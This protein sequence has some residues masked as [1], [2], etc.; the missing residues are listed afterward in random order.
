MGYSENW[1]AYVAYKAQSGKGVQASGAG[2]LILPQAGGQGGRL[3][4][5]AIEDPIIRR[6]AMQIRG[7]HGSQKTA[8]TYS[9]TIAIGASDPI[10]AAIM[11]TGYSAADLAITQATMT[12][13]T[14]GANTI[15]AAAGS[16][17]TQGLRVGDVIRAAGLPDAANNGKNF[18]ITGLTALTIT[19]A[20]TLVVN[21]VADNAFTITRPGRVLTNPG[22]GGLVKTYFT[23]E[24]HEYDIDGSEIFTDCVWSRLRIAMSPDGV[25]TTELG[26]TGTGQFETKEGV[27]APFFTAPADP[28]ALSLAAVESVLRVGTTDI[29]DLTSFDLTIDLQ[30][31]APSVTG[32]SKYAPDVFLG[33]Q[34]LTLNLTAMRKDLLDVADFI[35]ENQLSLH[36]LASEHENAPADFMSL[37]IPNF[38]YGGID[39]S[40]LSKQGGARTVTRSVPSS[41]IGIDSRGGAFDATQIK[42]QVSNAT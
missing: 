6:D 39:K 5:A 40:A 41:L 17:I 12:S 14:T 4:K 9:G 16:W 21:A 34:M 36:L 7:R 8:G 18:R 24:E 26:W 29:L 38:T 30:A 19:V 15:V 2:A 11:R 35:A 10:L 37:A 42:L 25:L 23:I 32:P 22:A 13:V 28:S 33:T 31:S 27:D 3:T 1:N 20:E